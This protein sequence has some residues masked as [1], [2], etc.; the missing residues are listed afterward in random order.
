MSIFQHTFQALLLLTAA[1]SAVADE[2]YNYGPY[3]QKYIA[4]CASCHVA[5]PPQK[6]TKAGWNTQMS[7][8]EQ[9][10]GTNAALD[11]ATHKEILAY[12]KKVGSYT[13]V[14]EKFN[15]S[16][17]GTVSYIIKKSIES[18]NDQM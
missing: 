17:K 9:H 1:S 8:L 6:L 3:P 15:I 13:K 10:Y 18:T 5:Y 11:D 14:M 16:S 4:E 12:Y 2:N 7:N